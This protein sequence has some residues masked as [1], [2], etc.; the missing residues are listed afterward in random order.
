VE[1]A[2]WPK[3]VAARIFMLLGQISA[4]AVAQLP[5]AER[6]RLADRC[7]QVADLADRGRNEK[8]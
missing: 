8:E 4:D 5:A 1:D 6:R 7:R 2:D 3:S